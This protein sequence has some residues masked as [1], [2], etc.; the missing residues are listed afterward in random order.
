V[1]EDE[2][3]RL[4][5]QDGASPPRVA[6][7]GEIDMQNARQ[8]RTCVEEALKAQPSELV[9]DMTE[10]T[11]IDSSGLKELVHAQ[12]ALRENGGRLAILNPPRIALRVLEIS[13]LARFLIIRDAGYEQ[14]NAFLRVDGAH[15]SERQ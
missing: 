6:L 13:G 8:L 1:Q 5:V 3:A 9:V 10:L 2:V 4:V 7:R 12:V 14:P 15:Q 11:F